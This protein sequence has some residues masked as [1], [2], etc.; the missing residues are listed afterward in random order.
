MI[1]QM[2]KAMSKDQEYKEAINFLL[3]GNKGCPKFLKQ[4][5]LEF[6][7]ETMLNF[8]KLKWESANSDDI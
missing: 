3:W 4:S 5:P 8:L 2:N 1:N 7:I 6:S